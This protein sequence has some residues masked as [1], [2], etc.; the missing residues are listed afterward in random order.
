MKNNYDKKYGDLLTTQKVAKM[1]NVSDYK[2]KSDMESNIPHIFCVNELLPK[3]R[4]TEQ[5]AREY[6][7]WV[8]AHGNVKMDFDMTQEYK[9]LPTSPRVH[10]FF[11]NPKKHGGGI[12]LAISR[13]GDF[14]NMNRMQKIMPYKTGNGHL[15][16]TLHNGLQPCAHNLVNLVWNDNALWK[17]HV[18]HINEIKADN[19]A[20]NLIS[21]TV[22]EHKHA[23]RLLDAIKTASTKEEKV[24]ARKAYRDFI[25][26]MRIDN[27]EA[28][29]EDLRVIGDL[30]Y[31]GESYMFVTQKSWEKYLESGNEYDLVIRG[32]YYYGKG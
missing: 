29:K 13:K 24:A 20:C 4:F 16:V 14:I 28:H 3:V 22:E 9:F 2:V 26:R 6:S 7:D 32:Q 5:E 1:A 8:A 21:L 31:P 19:R 27:K 23:H 10:K 15:Q 30:D 17:L 11:G 12:V 25:K 18:H